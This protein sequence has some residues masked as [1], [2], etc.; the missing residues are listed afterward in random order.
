M[1]ARRDS[2]QGSLPAHRSNAQKQSKAVRKRFFEIS[3]RPSTSING[4]KREI[5]SKGNHVEFL[6][7]HT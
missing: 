5:N 6:S 4:A 7:A 2:R 3:K 1:D